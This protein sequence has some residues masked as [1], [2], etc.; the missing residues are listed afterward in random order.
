MNNKEKHRCDFC[1]F[2][3]SDSEA[4][5]ACSECPMSSCEKLRCPNCGYEYLPEPGLVR[6]FRNRRKGKVKK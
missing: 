5:S 3:F 2:E 6:F 4:K 1:G